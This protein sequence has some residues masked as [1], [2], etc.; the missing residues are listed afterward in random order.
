MI[1]SLILAHPIRNPITK[2]KSLSIWG[3]ILVAYQAGLY[4]HANAAI[5]YA[6]HKIVNH[7]LPRVIKCLDPSSVLIL[8]LL[9]GHK[10]DSLL[11]KGEGLLEFSFPDHQSL[12]LS[13]SQFTSASSVFKA[14]T[15]DAFFESISHK[16][17]IK[18]V[19]YELWFKLLSFIVMSE[20]EDI[21]HTEFHRPPSLD[22]LEI[23]YSLVDIADKFLVSDLHLALICFLKD[24]MYYLSTA[25]QE[26]QLLSIFCYLKGLEGFQ[27]SGKEK[28]ELL[29]L[30]AV[31]LLGSF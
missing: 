28:V 4:P 14:M 20:S 7:R 19:E 9:E 21:L 8:N 27:F 1:N 30:A 18:D 31:S 2:S 11:F 25:K 24:A 13:K 17:V 29:E 6:K 23:V 3:Q 5:T 10:V 16:I 22:D 15:E 26:P 12:F